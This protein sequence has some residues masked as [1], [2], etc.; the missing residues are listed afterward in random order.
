MRSDLNAMQRNDQTK[1]YIDEDIKSVVLSLQSTND[2]LANLIIGDRRRGKDRRKLHTYIANDRRSGI[3]DRRKQ[4][5]SSPDGIEI[6]KALLEIWIIGHKKIADDIDERSKKTDKR[7]DKTIHSFNRQSNELL[8][9]FNSN[10]FSIIE[11]LKRLKYKEDRL[12]NQLNEKLKKLQ[13]HIDFF[14]NKQK[15]TVNHQIF[16]SIDQ[17]RSATLKIHNKA[18][19][20]ETSFEHLNDDIKDHK[21]KISNHVINLTKNFET[22]LKRLS[23]ADRLVFE[24][25]FNEF[26]RS[27]YGQIT[28]IFNRL[29]NFSNEIFQSKVAFGRSVKWIWTGIIVSIFF[30]MIACAISI[31]IALPY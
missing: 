22:E 30:S 26:E 18:Q 8:E 19:I 12:D 6:I 23:A 1:P 5:V 13:R 21:R 28:K 25:R 2:K 9:L 3:A 7:I 4:V 27:M 10:I 24:E 31:Y 16:R 20:L 29:E 15:G 17:L 14:E 11:V